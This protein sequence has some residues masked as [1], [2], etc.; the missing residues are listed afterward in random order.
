LKHCSF[1]KPH[2]CSLCFNIDGDHV[3]EIIKKLNPE[4]NPFVVVSKTFTTQETLTNRNYQRM[5][6]SKNLEQARGYS[7]HFVP[8]S[9][10]MEKVN[11]ELI[12]IMFFM[13]L[14]WR[15]FF[16]MECRWINHQFGYRL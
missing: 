14:G 16:I 2:E 7:Q 11:L 9:T 12:Q 1:I 4:T 15:S 5:V 6:L 8:V 10:N 13:G 3:N